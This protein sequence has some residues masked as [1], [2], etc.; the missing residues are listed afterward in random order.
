VVTAEVFSVDGRTVTLQAQA[1]DDDGVTAFQWSLGDLQYADGTSV[2]HTYTTPGT[3]TAIAWATDVT[4]STGWASVTVT[5][6]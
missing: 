5:V 1:A 6:E 3:Y 2:M 4:G